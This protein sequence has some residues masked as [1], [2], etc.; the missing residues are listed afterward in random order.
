MNEMG[1]PRRTGF[2]ADVFDTAQRTGTPI[3]AVVFRRA[4]TSTLE[5]F[6]LD[7]REEVDS[8]MAMLLREGVAFRDMW[9][10]TLAVGSIE[11]V[12]VEARLPEPVRG[13]GLG[14]SGGNNSE[15]PVE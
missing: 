9:P 7:K 14:N 13:N 15:S 1:N 2:Y 5:I 8:V 10:V 3:Y 11:R 6:K 12:H 4:T